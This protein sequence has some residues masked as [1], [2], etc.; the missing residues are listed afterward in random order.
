MP[1]LLRLLLAAG[2]L[3]ASLLAAVLPDDCVVVRPRLGVPAVVLPGQTFRVEL[4]E[5]VPFRE[6]SVA[7]RLVGER[8]LPCEHVAAAGSGATRTLE[9]TVPEG[10]PPGGYELEVT[11]GDLVRRRPRAVWVLEGLPDEAC[12]IVQLADLPTLGGDGSGDTLMTT[13]VDEIALI[14]PDLVLVT[15]DVNYSGRRADWL[16]LLDELARLEMPVIACPGN[17]EYKGLA[18]YLDSFGPNRHV[19]DIGGRR[20][21]SLDSAHGRDQLTEGQYAWLCEA[22]ETAGERDVLVQVHHPLFRRR[23]LDVHAED[24]AALCAEHEVPIV[25]SGHLHGD[26]NFD[27]TG[28]SRTDTPD[29]EGTKFVVTTA[30]GGDW[31]AD[32]EPTSPVLPGYRLIRLSGNELVDYTYDHDGDGAR[33]ASCSIPIG[34]LRVEGV[35]DGH[36]RVHNELNEG[37]AGAVVP[38]S[39]S[40]TT[41]RR[42]VPPGEVIDFRRSGGSLVH[43]VRID[44]PARSVVD[45][46]LSAD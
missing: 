27:G 1:L 15:G 39:A 14:A 17:H 29:F 22:F 33:D 23:N 12:T 10:A 36:V 2:A 25:L 28:R 26:V 44:L 40:G 21:I 41:P 8:A 11:R 5:A 7:V 4:R 32:G 13:I 6:E 45:V 20:V 24:L 43:R 9:V 31:R 38:V 19:V 37:F 35:G 18:G 34:H 3:L 46:E 30:A 42:A 16:L